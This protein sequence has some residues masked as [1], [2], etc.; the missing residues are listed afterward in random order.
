MNI[1]AKA[2]G[3]PPYELFVSN[4]GA[5]GVDFVLTAAAVPEPSTLAMMLLGFLGLGVL[6]YRRKNQPALRAV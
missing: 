6:T 5:N 1:F 3:A 2:G 4:G